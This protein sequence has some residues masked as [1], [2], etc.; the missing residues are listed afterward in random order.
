MGV[1]ASSKGS[2]VCLF[3][4][5][6]V[7]LY[8][9]LKRV[10]YWPNPVRLSSYGIDGLNTLLSYHSWVY[11]TSKTRGT[12][13]LMSLCT[14]REESGLLYSNFFFFFTIFI[15][16]LLFHLVVLNGKNMLLFLTAI[17]PSN[18]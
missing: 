18:S 13:S 1:E 10:Q 15:W 4:L 5:V 17:H 14:L 8:A 9:S 3:L 2:R 6:T 12:A 11:F 7:T 16:Y